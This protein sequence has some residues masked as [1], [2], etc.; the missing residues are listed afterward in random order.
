MA[1]PLVPVDPKV[2]ILTIGREILDGRVIDTNSVW[3]GEQLKEIGL[4]PRYA[5]RV[6]DQI[7]RVVEAYKIAEARSD[8]VLVTGG[9]GP[10][11]DDLTAEAFGKFLGEPLELNPE[12]LQQVEA[13]FAKLGRKM[14]EQQRKQ[15]YFPRSCAILENSEGTA[16]GFSLKRASNQAWYFMPGVPKEM[17]AMFTARILPELPKISGYRS[18]T[19]ATQFTSEGELQRQLAPVHAALLPTFE[20]TYRTRFP[21]NHVGLH[22]ICVD[23]AA[24]QTYERLAREIDTILGN[25]VFSGGLNRDIR[26][27]E[28]VVVDLLVQKRRTLGTVESCTG[29]LIASR[30]TD[31]AGSSAAFWSSWVT[32]D[33]SAKIALGIDPRLLQDHGAVSAEVARALAEAGVRKLENMGAKAPFCVATTGIAGPAGGSAEKPVGLCYI[34]VAG[35]GLE[36]RSD[37]VRGRPFLK[38]SEYKLLFSQKA[39]DLVRVLLLGCE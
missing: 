31:V 28:A 37:E 7:D 13:I 5:Q 2:E 25:T 34:A 11:A 21:E 38:R 23:D 18:S 36:T 29:G 12:A 3:L 22:G 26:S 19:W 15:A 27:L 10:T 33:N 24:K 20:M 6:D 14:I 1:K 17:K 9:L 39:L 16:P 4:V 35:P 30:V 8:I 32:Y